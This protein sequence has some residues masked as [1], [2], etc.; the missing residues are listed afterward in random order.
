MLICSDNST[1]T[2]VS[3]LNKEGG[4]HFIEMCAL[5]WRILAFTNSGRIQ[6]RARLVPGSL[7]VIADSLSRRDKVIQT[8]WS[9]HQQIFNQICTVWHTPVVDLFTTHLEH[10]LPIYVSPVQDKKACTGSRVPR[11]AMVLGSGG[12]LDQGTPS[13]PSLED[14]TKTT[15]F[16]QVPQQRGVPESTCV[17]SG[18]LKKRLNQG[19]PFM[20]NGTHRIRC[21]SPQ[22]LFSR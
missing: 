8:E 16:Q 11:D 1:V 10:K 15:T 2:V 3:Y 19:G 14:T 22:Q 5:I 9:L 17:A 12:S 7:N 4:T 20:A 13:A 21:T 6:V 18:F